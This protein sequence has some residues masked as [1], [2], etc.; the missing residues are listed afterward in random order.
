[1]HSHVT[2]RAQRVSEVARG[3]WRAGSNEL[4]GFGGVVCTARAVA[5]DD[6]PWGYILSTS[7][8]YKS[9][10]LLVASVSRTTRHKRPP[11]NGER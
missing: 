2:Q 8:E 3:V 4:I 9:A 1:M 11:D 6:R 7:R 10:P 5:I